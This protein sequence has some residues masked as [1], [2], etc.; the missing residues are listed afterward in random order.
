MQHARIDRRALVIGASSAALLG[1]TTPPQH[2]VAAAPAAPPPPPVP[3]PP[4]APVEP[5]TETLW[6]H[7]VTDPYRWMENASDARF[8]PYMRAQATYA[9]YV[10]DRIPALPAM[11][12]RVA[13]LSAGAPFISGVQRAG[14]AIFYEM[15]PAGANQYILYV[16]RN[17]ADHVLVD[18]TSMRQGDAHIS[19]DWWLASPDGSH[20][21]YGLSPSGSENSTAQIMEVASGTILPE[22]IDRTIYASPSW[23]PDGTGFFFNRLAEGAT[24]GT[25]S[26]YKNSACWL[27]KL[28]TDAHT[29]KRVLARGQY[30]SIAVAEIDFPVV[31]TTSGA[32]YA[33]ALVISGV[34]NEVAA[35]SARLSDIVA[36][37]P[38]WRRVCAPEDAVTN[39]A[40]RGD[41]LYLLTHKDA[42]R[43]KIVK[44][45][46][47]TPNVAA[48][49][50]IV[51]E[52]DRVISS[53]GAASDAVYVQDLDGGVGRVRRI[54]PN[55]QVSE[56]AL[57]YE[58]AVSG[59]Y[60][61]D[62]KAGCD[63]QLESWMKPPTLFHYDAASQHI[64]DTGILAQPSIDVSA[65]DSKRILVR[66]RDGVM[67]PLSI[68]FR[69]D[70][71]LNGQNPTIVNAYGSY[72]IVLNPAFNPRVIAF[73]EQGGVF[74]VAHVRGGGEFGEAWHEAGRK[75]TKPNTWRDLIDC[76]EE[77]IRQGY[78]RKEML[79]IQGGSAGGITVG[80]ALTERPDLFCAVISQVG[81]S[82]SLRS[83][84]M[85]SGPANIP[86][87]GSVADEAGF[88]GLYE[89]DS[90]QHV[91]DHTAYPAVIL[92]TGMSDPRVAPWQAGKMTARLQAATSSGKPIILRIEFDAGHGIGSTRAQRDSETADEYSFVLWQAGKAGFQPS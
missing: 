64:T 3:T 70:V 65:Y 44:T 67:V 74:A 52:S 21:V 14:D 43:F 76:S 41:Q 7:Q 10:L 81:D 33:L 25:E 88:R 30:P 46:A 53:V 58:G 27:H 38:R 60:V 12:Q 75:L 40:Q 83:E 34:Q 80:R 32:H 56:L 73:L 78:T 59:F 87:F 62:T 85:P 57:P 31:T 28:N 23:L 61:T 92:T 72:G 15:R 42:P 45:S 20:V 84:V 4:V 24:P 50:V 19:L 35:Y 47:A 2:Q 18:T 48:A 9:R 55:D 26:Y 39:I 68:I 79:A 29:D 66:A 77:M 5:V 54:T 69:K 36:G 6:S 89:M 37:H 82:D 49:H 13:A 63:V 11:Q 16:R 1:C 8:E 90:Y 86:E 22:R 17:G 91:V 51:P 71:A